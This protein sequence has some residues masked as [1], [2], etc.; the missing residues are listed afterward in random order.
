[1]G[2]LFG[3]PH[4][5]IKRV[6]EIEIDSRYYDNDVVP[7]S[8]DMFTYTIDEENKI[9]QI[10]GFVNNNI[11]EA[12]IPYRIK[13]GDTASHM[14]ATTTS[15][16][17]GAFKDNPYLTTMTMPNT[18]HEI[19]TEC[20]ANCTA[21]S[22]VIIPRSIRT[23]K[24]DAFYGCTNLRSM[25]IGIG[26]TTIKQDAFANCTKLNSIF[27]PYN[28]TEIA[29]N[30]FKDSPKVKIIC[31][32]DSK[33]E[34]YAKAHNIPY[35][36][37]SY[38]LDDDLTENSE[39]LVTSGIIYK[40]KKFLDDKINAHLNNKED[41]H[42]SS[43]FKDVSL[44]G[45]SIFDVSKEDISNSELSRLLV[46]KEYIDNEISEIKNPTEGLAYQKQYD[47]RLQTNNK[48]VVGAINELHNKSNTVSGKL[49]KGWNNISLN[50]LYP[51]G[52][53]FLDKPYVYTD[54]GIS[55]DYRVKNL[56]V[57][58]NTIKNNMNTFDMYVPT[59]CNY[60]FSTTDTNE[61]S[62]YPMDYLVISYY[63][64]GQDGKDLDTATEIIN[65]SW[66]LNNNHVGY[67]IGNEIKDSSG[68]TLIYWGG[69]NT[70]GGSNDNTIKYYESVYF[71][72]K[73]IQKQLPNEDIDIILYGI[74]FSQR[75]EGNVHI[76]L[77]TYICS[78]TPTITVTDR[79]IHLSGEGLTET[80]KD[81]TS[82]ICN[83]AQSGTGHSDK[84][85]TDYTPIF[86]IT[87]KKIKDD[88]NYRTI[89]VQSL[90]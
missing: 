27:I 72:I 20:F 50:T 88:S 70:G 66:P 46:N 8:Q 83:V 18:L 11:S 12:V 85:K 54:E 44:Y 59:E 29:D 10:T 74:W 19:P 14:Y 6:T 22:R 55:V 9:A 13:Y 58:K 16:A 15:I 76:S 71:N 23:I 78:T 43:K 82:L 62:G 25:T 75:N 67:N 87:F 56:E 48:T 39:N 35:S 2:F 24:E 47:I 63:Y 37:I 28:V 17:N 38:T 36:L 5:L 31:Y 51:I 3:V 40:W 89:I 64:T 90:S 81:N 68:T 49:Q 69:D 84:Y 21:L 86:K 33:A 26:V 34:E 30:V 7:S 61:I 57:N 1:M 41:P 73:D 45:N 32:K 52:W 80:Y 4:K 60:L 79:L 77:N 53:R 65:T 42:D